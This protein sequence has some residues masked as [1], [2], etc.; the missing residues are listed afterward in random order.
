MLFDFNFCAL[1]IAPEEAYSMARNAGKGRILK[2]GK[3][4]MAYYAEHWSNERRKS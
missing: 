1:G 2:P 4:L 3:H